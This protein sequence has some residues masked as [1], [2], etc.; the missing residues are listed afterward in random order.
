MSVNGQTGTVVLDAGDVGA[1][2]DDNP[3]GFVD[4]SGAAAAAPVQSVNGAVGTVVLDATDVGAYPDSNPSGF[5]DAAGA[6]RLSSP[7]TARPA[8]WCWTRRMW[9][10]PGLEPVQFHGC[11]RA[12]AAAPVQSVNGAGRHGGAGCDGMSGRT[13]T[14]TPATS[15]MLGVRRFSR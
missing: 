1:Y 4:A 3:S 6:V 14:R 9:C 7:S 8:R 2:A 12:A 15:S 5:I 10:V 11:G 13:R